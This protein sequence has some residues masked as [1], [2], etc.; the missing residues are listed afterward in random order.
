MRRAKR[1]KETPGAQQQ[2]D[3]AAGDFNPET[4]KRERRK[5]QTKLQQVDSRV[6]DS[7]G[8]LVRGGVDA[9][10]C[11]QDGCPGCFYPC[12]AC[13]STRCGPTCRR[14]RRWLYE[15]LETEGGGSI[16]NVYAN[17]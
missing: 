7:Q 14:D 9:C 8:R 11:L 17:V 16:D 4:S 3:E 15:R 5:L 13:S 10:D 2:H 6:Y 12:S 1:G